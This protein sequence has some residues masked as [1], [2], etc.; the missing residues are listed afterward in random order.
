[1]KYSEYLAK[2]VSHLHSNQPELELDL[3]HYLYQI[4][5]FFFL[6]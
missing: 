1:M 3:P 6:I 2:F 5:F 4:N